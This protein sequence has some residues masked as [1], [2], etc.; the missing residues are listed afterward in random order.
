MELANIILI[1]SG[2]IVALIGVGAILNPNFAKLI[3]APGGPRI[4]G[5]VALIVGLIILIVGLVY[6][7]PG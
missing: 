4:K 1:I 7:I 5:M 2:I 3:N 6:Q